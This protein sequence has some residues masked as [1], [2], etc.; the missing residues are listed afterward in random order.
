MA[1]ARDALTPGDVEAPGA[2]YAK[3]AVAPGDL[4]DLIPVVIPEFDP[5]LTW[6]PCRWQSRDGTTLPAAGDECLV[7][8]D[9]RRQPW[10][11]AWWP[12]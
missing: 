3:I 8:F 11:V 1:D 12:F 6:G 9:N 5:T 7:V 2:V 4:N 10:I